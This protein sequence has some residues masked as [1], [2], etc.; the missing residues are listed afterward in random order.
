[1]AGNKKAYTRELYDS[2]LAYFRLHPGDSGGAAKACGCAYKTAHRT[3]NGEA[4]P[5][6]PWALPIKQVLLQEEAK[7]AQEAAEEEAR[8][9]AAA[10]K[11]RQDADKEAQLAKQWDE[12][13]LKLARND[14]MKGLGMMGQVVEGVSAAALR[15]NEQLK[16][17]TDSTG[18]AIDIPPALVLQIL[19]RFAVAVRGL[20][21]AAA[22]LVAIERVRANL[23]SSIVQVDVNSMTPEELDREVE[24]AK[25]AAARAKE[26]G[27]GVITGGKKTG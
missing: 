2:L 12:T 27:F 8:Q 13:I 24:L 4:R 15:M 25:T 5:L 26:L 11:A 9:R 20:T 22:S 21:D 1:M 16:R 19:G 17:G 10:D 7:R 14:V 3:W 18:K 6:Y 23:P